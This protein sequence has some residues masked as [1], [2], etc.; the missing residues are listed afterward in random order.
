MFNVAMAKV[1]YQGDYNYCYCTKSSH[2]SFVL[3]EALKNDIHIETS[4]AFDINLIDALHE[5]GLL[6]KDRYIICNGFKKELYIEN[7]AGLINNGWKNT[8]PVLD[9]M[10]EFYALKRLT[11][12]KCKL[13]IR[14]A[15]EDNG[16][17][18]LPYP[19]VLRHPVIDRVYPFFH[20]YFIGR[21]VKS[22]NCLFIFS[23]CSC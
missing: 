16:H 23:Y 2:F 17:E 18:Q 21:P 4:S 8:I 11:N 7:I 6:D 10:A 19:F 14:I 15:A 9:N 3:E 20:F 1:D 22:R 5:Q 12:E 13:G